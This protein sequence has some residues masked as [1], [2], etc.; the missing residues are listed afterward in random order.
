MILSAPNRN[1]NNS[2][3]DQTKLSGGIHCLVFLN[4]FTLFFWKE[5]CKARILRSN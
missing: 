1:I 5:Y 3:P 2:V 4:I